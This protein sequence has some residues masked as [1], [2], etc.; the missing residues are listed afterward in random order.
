MGPY[1]GTKSALDIS[2]GPEITL[3]PSST[4]GRL[5]QQIGPFSE[6]RSKRASNLLISVIK[7]CLSLPKKIQR[8]N[9][10]SK[11]SPDENFSLK[12]LPHA[13]F[14]VQMFFVSKWIL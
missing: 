8:Q 14:A 7:S 4:Y 6:V 2:S 13:R 5:K 1:L 10:S 9:I 11:K 3:E 12:S